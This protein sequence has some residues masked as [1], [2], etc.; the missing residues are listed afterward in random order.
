MNWLQRH[1]ERLAKFAPQPSADE[2]RLATAIQG[3]WVVERH[4]AGADGE[5]E[6]R[7]FVTSPTLRG[8]FKFSPESAERR[9]RL[10]FP[11]LPDAA[12][13]VAVRH[14]TDRVSSYLTEKTFPVTEARRSF[15]RD[16]AADGELFRL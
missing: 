12:V 1:R 2:M 7:I 10:A 5:I 15:V 3:A 9:I 4:A 6:P 8:T 13:V 14:L 16:W 11:D